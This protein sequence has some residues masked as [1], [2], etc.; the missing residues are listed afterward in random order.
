MGETIFIIEHDMN[1]VKE[2]ADAI[3]VLNNGKLLD[4]GSP[5]KVLNN[6]KVIEAYL[7]E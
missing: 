1:F 3:V 4:H 7:G 6:P 2:V 5:K